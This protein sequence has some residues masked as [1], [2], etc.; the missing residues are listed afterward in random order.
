MCRRRARPWQQVM[1]K[2]TEL[3]VA[4]SAVA[5]QVSHLTQQMEAS[6]AALDNLQAA[7][8]ALQQEVATAI[9][10]WQNALQNSDAANDAA[11]QQVA[12]DMQ[13]TVAQLQA[14]DP[15]NAQTPPANQ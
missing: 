14:A 10:D 1:D 3:G 9:T 13:N 5:G 8:T 11:V 15:A 7:D 12:T 2:L 4:M 6:M